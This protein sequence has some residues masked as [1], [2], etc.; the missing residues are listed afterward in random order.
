MQKNIR[1]LAAIM[2]TDMVGY[3]ALMQEDENKA[4]KN[5]ERHRIVLEQLI[6]NHHGLILQYYGDGTL[7]IFGSAIEAIEC[8]VEIQ[9][10]LQKNPKIPLRIGMHIGDIVYSDDGVIGDAVN[11]A[12]RIEKLSVAGGVLISDKVYDEIKNHHEFSTVTLGEF[13]LKNVKHPMEL[14]AVTNEGLQIPAKK[15]L[16]SSKL[17]R[18]TIK[19]KDSQ[20]PLLETKLYVPQPRPDLIQRTHLTER[21]NMGINNK[22]ILISA[23]AGFGKTTLISEWISQSEIP[24]T[25]ISLDKSDNDPVHFMYYLIAALKSINANIG[26]PALTM[27]HSSQQ[28]P[29]E[30]IMPNLIKEIT[31]IPY[32]CVLV[33]DDYHSIDAKQV[34]TI[35]EFLLDHLPPQMHIVIT[36][37]VDP[38]L[39]LARLRVRN[40]LTEVRASDL[41]FTIAEVTEFFN[42]M[43]NLELSSHDISM[44]ESRTEGWIAGLQLAALSMQG[45]KDIQMFIKT[46]AGDDR[47]IVDYLAEEVLNLQPEHVQNFLLQTSILNRLSESLCDFVTD[48]KGSQKMLD[49]L[50]RANLFIVSLDNKRQWYR[51]HHLFADLLRQR[52]YQTKSNLVPELHLRA[53]RWCEQNK[54]VDDAVEHALTAKDFERAAYLIKEH[55]DALWQRFAHTKLYRWLAELPDNFISSSPSLC[56]FRAWDQL[57]RG[58]QDAAEQS[59]QA[60]EQGLE[61]SPDRTTESSPIELNQLP[62]SES[63]KLR[64]RAASI[65]AFLAFF[66]GDMSGIISY[67]RQALEYLPEQDLTWRS[68]ITIALGDAHSIKG[69]LG[70]AYNAQLEALKV[71]K[72]AD[73]IHLVMLANMKFAITLR[74]QGKLQRTI[75][76]CRQQVQFSKE[77]G[78]SQTGMVG[79]LSAIWGEVLAELNDLDGA[80]QLTK[81]CD[82]LIKGG[83]NVAMLGRSYQCLIRILFSRGDLAGAEEIIQ[84][85]EKIARKSDVPPWITIQMTAWQVRLWLAQDKLDAASRWVGECGLYA[86][87]ESTL[88]HEIDYVVLI[89][90]ITLARILIAQEQLEKAIGL[91]QHLLDAAEAGGRTTRVIEIRLLQ[92]LAFRAG[93]DTLQAMTSL[94]QALSIAEPGGYIRIFI[95]EGPPIAELF[96]IILDKKI[97]IPRVYIKKLLSAFRLHRLVETDNGLVE[98]LSERE[99]EVLRMITGGLSN[100]QIMEELFL[101]LSTV[102]THIRNIYSKLNVHSRMEVTVKAREL[103]LL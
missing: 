47:H 96:E 16:K 91:L 40:Q 80:L 99:L 4:I 45:R 30:S 90:Y 49:E 102:K 37:R 78:L 61:T 57:V 15:V 50:E 95:D 92:A 64:G 63:M 34:H 66:R 93:G 22:L 76:L 70:A 79:L 81:K 87:G 43:M 65:R 3:T 73:D 101:S 55:V 75:E 44:L 26:E 83:E 27:L 24:V 10:E 28:P 12:A 46:F 77:C 14:F 29:I 31:D 5:R 97:D 103:N 85:M 52:L 69:D 38:P 88:P 19:I 2:F 17:K 60:A 82:E 32:D 35:V 18:A 74:S 36:T 72:G 41:C 54:L 6:Q 51:Y 21:L 59:L 13:E 48:Q 68:S 86:D 1:Q 11:I 23:P 9:Q 20:Y 42:K 94:G 67:A 100:K 7:S 89:K 56:I 58:Q 53:S 39:P 8:A 25:W 62:D 33:L 71:C 84:K 98:R